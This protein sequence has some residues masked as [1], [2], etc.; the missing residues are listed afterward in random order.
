M[1]DE[2]QAPVQN[3]LA[4]AYYAAG[5]YQEALAS[6]DAAL[7]LEPNPELQSWVDQLRASVS[8]AAA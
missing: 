6:F 4:N 7:K 2:F 1:L 5:R 8:A 3:A